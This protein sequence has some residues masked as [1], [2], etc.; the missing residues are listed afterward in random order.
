MRRGAGVLFACLAVLLAGA[1][2][3]RA[4]DGAV[5]SQAEFSEPTGRY[6]HGILGD[7]MEWGNL[8]ITVGRT[9]GDKAGVFQ[10][11]SSLTYEIRLPETLVYEDIA[12]RLWD[13]TGDGRPEVVVIQSHL[14][15]GARLLVIGLEAG[16]PVA[17]AA[18]PFIG[19]SHRWL[20]PVGAADLDGDG[21]IEIA[22]IDR[23]HLAKVLR[24]WRL[25]G[26]TLGHVAD[27]PGLTNHKIGWDVIP[28]GIRDCGG[29]P[30]VI[31]ADAGWRR[32]VA[33]TFRGG[34][35]VTRPLAAFNSVGDFAPVMA[36]RPE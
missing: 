19:Q 6:D 24:I 10:G 23:P 20:A 9:Q 2:V 28:G 31:T 13:V 26:G 4:D 21:R 25:E 27:I 3:G 8:R 36:C 12:P 11:K 1:D 17:L 22:Y 14:A 34:K 15:K 16:K 29:G 18:T 33:T 5:I 35:P 7:A 32:V 30:E